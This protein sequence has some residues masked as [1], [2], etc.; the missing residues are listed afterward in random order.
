MI[1]G[2]IFEWLQNPELMHTQDLINLLHR[3][4]SI[5]LKF[6]VK[7][8]LGLDVACGAMSI[9][10]WREHSALK[11]RQFLLVKSV[12][13]V[14]VIA[15]DAYSCSASPKEFGIAFVKLVELL[16]NELVE[17]TRD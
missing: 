13:E 17:L 15:K 10:N 8:E 6:S 16:E 12:K 7:P 14:L 2:Q 5:L 1:S 9:I 4:I 11:P 3:C